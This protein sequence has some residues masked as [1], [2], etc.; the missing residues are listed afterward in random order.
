MDRFETIAID[1]IAA[2][3]GR[4]V[5][6]LGDEVMGITDDPLCGAA[7]GLHLLDSVDAHPKLPEVP[8]G[9]GRGG[10]VLRR[11]GDVY[12]PV[13]NIASR[14]TAAAKPGTVLVDRELATTLEQE[15]ALQLRRRRPISGY[16]ATRTCPPGESSQPAVAPQIKANEFHAPLSRSPTTQH[17][18]QLSNR[19]PIGA[20]SRWIW[21]GAIR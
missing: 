6:T 2:A 19:M 7:I 11:F 13:V 18:V 15:P 5:K 21:A 20:P 12:G 10:R 16:A 9:I 3:G 17:G 1:V 8:R 14:L 4:V